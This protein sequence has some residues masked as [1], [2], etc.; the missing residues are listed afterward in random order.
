VGDKA[1]HEI[2][3]ETS[4]DAVEQFHIKRESHFTFLNSKRFFA[5]LKT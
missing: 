5:C 3:N 4:C 2:T 1:T